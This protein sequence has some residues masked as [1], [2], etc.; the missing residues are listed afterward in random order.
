MLHLWL[1]QFCLRLARNLRLYLERKNCRL[2]RR[3]CLILTAFFTH[4]L[5]LG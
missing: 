2:S 1:E 4:V 3:N 5:N